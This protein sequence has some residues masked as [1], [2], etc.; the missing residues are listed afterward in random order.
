MKFVKW[1]K[2]L[3][4]G[5]PGLA[6]LIDPDKFNPELIRLAGKK[7][8]CFLVG[9]S[10]LESGNSEACVKA[11]K[12]LSEVPVIL[13][14]GDYSQL[15]PKADGL[16]LLSLLSG[17]NPE[18]LIGQQVKAAQEIVRMKLPSLPVA[19]ILGGSGHLSTTLKVTGTTSIAF[20]NRSELLSTCLAAQQLGFK[21]IYLEAGSG[22][23]T[24]VPVTVINYLK[25]HIHVPLIVGGGIKSAKAARLLIT[26]GADLVVVG[27][28]LENNVS[29][30]LELISVV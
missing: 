19:Y 8:S 23:N 6:I 5:K 2:K 30:I 18:Y 15:T 14:P 16:L 11:I 24:P 12:K 29:L 20:E 3:G 4:S 22:A 26:A 7:V 27:N 21:A 25:K 9:G 13:F 1:I 28:A 17:R 10:V